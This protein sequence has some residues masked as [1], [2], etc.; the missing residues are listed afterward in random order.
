MHEN[1]AV[2]WKRIAQRRPGD[3]AVRE[4]G[5]SLA[6]GEFDRQARAV[7]G[8]LRSRGVSAGDR[9]AFFLHNTAEY[10]VG[11]YACLKLEAIPVSVNYRY[12]AAEVAGLLAATTPVAL[13]FPAAQ[14][15]VA[16]DAVARIGPVAGPGLLVE[17]GAGGETGGAGIVPFGQL[18]EAAPAEVPDPGSEAELYLFTG[19]TTGTPQAVVWSIGDLLGVQQSSI[20]PPVGLQVPADLEAAVGLAVEPGRPRVITLPLAPFIHATALFSAMNTLALGGTVVIYP[21]PGLDAVA[22]ADL[23]A[24]ERVTRLIVAGDAVAVPVLDALERRAGDAGLA[25]DSVISSG[26]RFSDDTKRRLHRLGGI[27][28]VDILASTEGGP[29]AMAITRHEDE[30]PARFRLAEQAVVLDEQQQEVQDRPGAIG[31]LAFRGVLPK[32]Y[33]ND[34]ERTARTYPVLRGVRHVS[35]GD[36]V[37]VR[38]DRYIELLGRG[39]S[40]VNTG[41]EKVY[42]AEVEQVLLDHPAVMDAVVFGVPHGRWGEQVAAVVA[43]EPGAA[44]TGADLLDFVGQRLAGYKKPRRLRVR[45]RLERGPTGKLDMTALRESLSLSACAREEVTGAVEN[46]PGIVD[47]FVA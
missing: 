9:V 29:Y 42:P 3:V 1:Y 46:P 15:D 28:I 12:R 16:L 24:R 35:P 44:V 30:L 7:A 33:L 37:R 27:A 10:L 32:G 22:V 13:V 34:P 17:V 47:G 41:G 6:Y 21:E 38:A 39:S 40:V 26:M 4:G 5:R 20:Y 19:G 36:H 31:V 11:F 45:E 25:L 18:L 2:L 14:R 23:I 43:L 8:A